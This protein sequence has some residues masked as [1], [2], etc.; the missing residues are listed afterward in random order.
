MEV[1]VIYFVVEGQG[2]LRVGDEEAK[3]QTGSL[4]I[5]P[6][7]EVRSIT[8]DKPMRVLAVQVL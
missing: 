4:V 2:R 7:E 6:A 5:V 1:P 3:L 8:G